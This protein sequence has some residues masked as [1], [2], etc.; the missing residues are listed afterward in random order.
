M[1]AVQSLRTLL[2][3]AETTWPEE[4]F[5]ELEACARDIESRRKGVYILSDD[6]RAAIEE[7]IAQADR[8]EFVSDERRAAALRRYGL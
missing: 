6:E 3:R 2:D 8:G 1:G 7:G 4:D 5:A